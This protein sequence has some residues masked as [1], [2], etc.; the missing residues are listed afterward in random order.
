MAKHLFLN[1]IIMVLF[2]F[3]CTG[4]IVKEKQVLKPTVKLA[5]GESK[6]I[7]IHGLSVNFMKMESDS[8]ALIFLL[9][10]DS[11][12]ADTLSMNPNKII[13]TASLQ[14]MT[15]DSGFR[16]ISM[17]R[18]TRLSIRLI[19]TEFETIFQQAVDLIYNQSFESTL[20][21]IDGINS[22][23]LQRYHSDKFVTSRMVC[24]II[25]NFELKQIESLIDSHFYNKTVGTNSIEDFNF[26][27]YESYFKGTSYDSSGTKSL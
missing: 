26:L 11:T 21:I 9:S 24:I 12:L 19:R 16:L 17:N 8:F 22:E 3:S 10:N 23:D 18:H 2:V 14:S 6:L 13:L 5:F 1:L 20:N 15:V 27:P 7:N 25:G 4:G